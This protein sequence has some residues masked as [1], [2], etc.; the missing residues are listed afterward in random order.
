MA[1][2]IYWI[3]TG[4]ISVFLALST[5][6]YFFSQVTKEGLRDLG[7]PDFFIIQLGILQ[8]VA[9]IILLVPNLPM[10][11]KDWAY[12]GVGL[13]L[14]TALVAHIAHKDS[15]LIMILLVVL[16]VILG[17]SRYSLEQLT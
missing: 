7:F 8:L 16:F 2:T 11:L 5:Y 12:A 13:F 14:L 10:Y 1:T 15:I 6:T 9:A 17:V 4:L 3:S